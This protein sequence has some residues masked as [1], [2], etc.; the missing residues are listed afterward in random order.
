MG[1]FNINKSTGG[2]NQTAGMPATYPAE[3]VMMSDGVTSVEEALGGK[4]IDAGQFTEEIPANTESSF[5]VNVGITGTFA[6]VANTNYGVAPVT[7][8]LTNTK[9]FAIIYIKNN[10]SSALNVTVNWIACKR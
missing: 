1:E 10:H 7:A 5:N 9:G 4:V 3:Q 6:C 2:L 8:V